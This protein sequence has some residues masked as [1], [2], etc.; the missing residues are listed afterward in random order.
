MTPDRIPPFTRGPTCGGVSMRILPAGPIL[1]AFCGKDH[2]H[3]QP[4][5]TILVAINQLGAATIDLSNFARDLAGNPAATL[6]DLE[7]V[8]E[9]LADALATVLDS[10]PE[11]RLDESRTQLLGALRR[12]LKGWTE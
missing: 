1:C 6:S 11:A 9:F 8:P 5:H 7:E 4:P 3:G 10:L 12:Y 2:T